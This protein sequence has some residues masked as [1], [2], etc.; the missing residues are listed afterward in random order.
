MRC[1]RSSRAGTDLNCQSLPRRRGVL[2]AKRIR[3][4]F[5]PVGLWDVAGTAQKTQPCGNNRLEI[6]IPVYFRPPWIHAS[7]WFAACTVWGFIFLRN[8]GCFILPSFQVST[9]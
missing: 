3:A 6:K 2:Q 5:R 8:V 9:M 7:R 1:E 4:Y